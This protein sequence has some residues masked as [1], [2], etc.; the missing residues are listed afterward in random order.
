MTFLAAVIE[1]ATA[2]RLKRREH[3]HF[4]SIRRA[5]GSATVRTSTRWSHR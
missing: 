1:R 3:A 4:R 5:L 2:R